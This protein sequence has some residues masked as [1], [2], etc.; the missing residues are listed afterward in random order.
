VQ[1]SILV[2]SGASLFPIAAARPIAKQPATTA[3]YLRRPS[4]HANADVHQKIAFRIRNQA[5]L[6]RQIREGTNLPP[7]EAKSGA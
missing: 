2:L 7:A 1:R 3:A 6:Q 5:G 4:A